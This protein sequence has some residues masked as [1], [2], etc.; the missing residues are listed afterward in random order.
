MHIYDVYHI[1]TSLSS[2]DRYKLNLFLSITPVSRNPV[3]ASAFLGFLCNWFS[4]FITARISFTSTPFRPKKNK[5]WACCNWE[6]KIMSCA[7][8]GQYNKCMNTVHFVEESCFVFAGQVIPSELKAERRLAG[9][10]SSVRCSH[11]YQAPE[12]T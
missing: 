7:Q 9:Q 8:V 1:H 12:R 11:K 10:L 6:N 2:Y 5:L 4:C 3:E